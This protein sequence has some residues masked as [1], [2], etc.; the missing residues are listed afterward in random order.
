M[1]Q[2][3]WHGLFLRAHPAGPFAQRARIVEAEAMHVAHREAGPRRLLADARQRRQHA[4]REHI[5]AH[6]IAAP[7]VLAEQLRLEP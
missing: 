1:P 3:P 5:V 7:A 4:A 6:E 2:R